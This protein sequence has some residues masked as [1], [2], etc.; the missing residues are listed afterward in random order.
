MET[1]KRVVSL[2]LC[3]VMLVGVVPFGAMATETTEPETTETIPVV[4]ETEEVTDSTDSTGETEEV[5]DEEH[6]P[7]VQADDENQQPQTA[8][9][10][11]TVTTTNSKEVYVLVSSIAAAGDYLIVSANSATNSAHMLTASTNGVKDTSSVVVKTEN[12]IEGNSVTY[13][14]SPAAAAIWTASNG[15]KLYNSNQS[16]YLRYNNSSLTVTN[17]SSDA[18][19][20]KTTTNQLYRDGSSNDYWVRYS[21]GW[22]LAKIVLK[23]SMFIRSRRLTLLL[24]PTSLV[25]T[26][27][28]VRI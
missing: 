3:F 8:T 24:L 25:P 1:F 2:L 15:W 13:I 9:G 18:T 20:W 12:N 17:S 16:R 26:P 14:E 4:E 11:G 19:N 6:Q 27:S 7:A 5:T 28:Q 10:T 23:M 21:D 22:V